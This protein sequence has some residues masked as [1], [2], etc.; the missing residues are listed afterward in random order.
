MSIINCDSSSSR[1]GYFFR[2]NSLQK[3]LLHYKDKY[4]NFKS[5]KVFTYAMD[6]KGLTSCGWAYGHDD[7]EQAKKMPL[8]RVKKTRLIHPVN[9]SILMERLSL[10]MVSFLFLFRQMITS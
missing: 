10:K 3:L 7:I 1:T 9:L 6:E 5:H 8:L 4:V 2:K